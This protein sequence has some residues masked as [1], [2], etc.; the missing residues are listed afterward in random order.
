[1]KLGAKEWRKTDQK[2]NE[3][4]PYW[5]NVFKAG[6]V[7]QELA[8]RQDKLWHMIPIFGSSEGDDVVT[9]ASLEFE[10]PIARPIMCRQLIVLGHW[11]HNQDSRKDTGRN[12]RTGQGYSPNAMGV[13][14]GFSKQHKA[15]VQAHN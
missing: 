13:H 1:M 5:A 4:A 3:R 15:Q 9:L 14:D 8:I 7:I 12:R 11:P 6:E 10:N 2:L